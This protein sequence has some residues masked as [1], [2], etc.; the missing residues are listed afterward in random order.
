MCIFMFFGGR[1][2]NTFTRNKGK[3]LFEANKL[4]LLSVGL[5][6][7][8]IYVRYIYNFFKINLTFA[9]SF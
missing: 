6:V 3:P 1:E 2:R 7:R 8:V 4:F 9:A 5:P